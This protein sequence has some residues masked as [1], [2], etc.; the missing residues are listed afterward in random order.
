MT[1]IKVFL[2]QVTRDDAPGRPG[3]TVGVGESDT[4]R[5]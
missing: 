1:R 3:V 2:I 5:E 4:A